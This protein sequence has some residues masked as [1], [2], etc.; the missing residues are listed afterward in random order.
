MNKSQHEM[1]LWY[2][3]Y[4]KDWMTSFNVMAMNYFE[5]GVYIDLLSMAW[6]NDGLPNDKAFVKQ[7]LKLCLEEWEACAWII[8]K[9][10]YDD[11]TKYRNKRQEIE[12]NKYLSKVVK[13]RKAGHLGGIKKASSKSKAN[14]KQ[15]LSYTETETET[16]TDLIKETKKKNFTLTHI[17]QLY[18]AYPVHVQKQAAMKAIA[19][20]LKNGKPFDE[21]LATVKKFARSK[22]GRGE[23]CPYP[24]TWFNQGRYED[25]PA[26]WEKE[27]SD[28]KEQ[29]ETDIVKSNIENGYRY[30]PRA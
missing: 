7:M 10:F 11:G 15:K 22:K 14:A 4:A 25:D 23:F 8:D 30:N 26:M 21:L 2:P 27:Y 12:R 9:C 29:T 1:P 28:K 17:E 18:Q 24:A 5:K 20:V 16:E 3:H 6:V 13:L 19:K